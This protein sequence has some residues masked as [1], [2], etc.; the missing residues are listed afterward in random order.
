MIEKKKE[1]KSKKNS[2]NVDISTSVD[3]IMDDWIIQYNI[4]LLTNLIFIYLY[5]ECLF[6]H[7]YF[8][9]DFFYFQLEAPVLN[10]SWNYGANEVKVMMTI[11]SFVN[12]PSRVNRS[13][14]SA[15][16]QSQVF[17]TCKFADP[18]IFFN[19]MHFFLKILYL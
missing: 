6:L 10:W 18:Q 13:Y 8:M 17:L 4:S 1:K 12:K 11:T 3:L 2:E 5:N 19:E 9:S 16:T 14:V 15:L 7:W